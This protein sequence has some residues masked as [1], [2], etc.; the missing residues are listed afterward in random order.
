MTPDEAV[1]AFVRLGCEED[2]RHSRKNY[3]WLEL[4]DAEGRQIAIFNVPTS[5][6][7]LRKGTM[8][9]GLLKPNGISDEDHLAELLAAPDPLAAFRRVLPTGGPRYHPHGQ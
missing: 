6:S 5:K 4:K 8:L 2:K 9:N 1:A 7:P 3:R